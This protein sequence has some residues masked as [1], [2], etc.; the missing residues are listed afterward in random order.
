MH[1][2]NARSWLAA[3]S[4]LFVALSA[5]PS[6]VTARAATLKPAQADLL[7]HGLSTGDEKFLKNLP[8]M[9]PEAAAKILEFRKTGKSFSSLP[10][11]REVSGLSAEQFNKL[12]DHY[13]RLEVA[14]ED[15]IGWVPGSTAPPPDLH[16]DRGKRGSAAAS[17]KSQSPDPN[18]AAKAP[19]GGAL[20]LEVKMGYYSILPGYNLENLDPQKKKLFLD[21]INNE[22][23]SCGCSNDTLGFCLVNDSSCQVVRA[24]VRKV[25]T[26]IFGAPPQ[27]PKEGD[28]AH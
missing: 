27:A 24:R 12:Q 26:D 17:S 25:Y 28:G 22:K 10:Q 11:A 9:T 19:A 20:D 6:V 7:L 18:A 1:R 15:S 3:A 16:T 4:I 14:P 8:G 13:A 2:T 5:G 23:C 21:T